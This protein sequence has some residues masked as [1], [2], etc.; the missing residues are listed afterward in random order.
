LA[1]LRWPGVCVVPAGWDFNWGIGR[2]DLLALLQ[3]PL[4]T[5]AELAQVGAFGATESDAVGRIAASI[6]VEP[7]LVRTRLAATLGADTPE[8]LARLLVEHE[9]ELVYLTMV[10]GSFAD[11][12]AQPHGVGAFPLA[13]RVGGLSAELSARLRG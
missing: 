10:D 4:P 8:E 7:V 2:V 11:S 9:G 1:V 13:P 5:A 12:L 6:G 3:A